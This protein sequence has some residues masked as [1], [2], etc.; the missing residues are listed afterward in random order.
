MKK[1]AAIPEW[2]RA[3]KDTKEIGIPQ[4]KGQ[5]PVVLS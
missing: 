5:L 1:K 2:G 3:M 4:S